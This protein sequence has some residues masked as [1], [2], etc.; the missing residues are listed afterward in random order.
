MTV[1]CGARG[2]SSASRIQWNVC[3]TSTSQL[4]LNVSQVWWWI[5]RISGE[6]PALSTSVFGWYCSRS[7]PARTGS[8][9]SAVTV[10]S[11]PSSSSRNSS[12]CTG[13][14]ATATTLAP[15]SWRATVT[16]RPKPRPAPV[17]RAVV[18]MSSC[19]ATGGLLRGVLSLALISGRGRKD[20]FRFL[21][22]C[23]VRCELAAADEQERD[24]DAGEADRAADPERPLEA[25]GQR[26]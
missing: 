21:G 23:V 9:T 2:R 25:A 17:T 18:P 7:E 24:R 15:A 16:A 4:R 1:L 3:R 6:A 8:A 10:V 26:G 14:R 12:S 19:D 22:G 20:R 11:E 5:G 13:L